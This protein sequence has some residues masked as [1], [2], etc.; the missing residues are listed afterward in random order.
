MKF[1]FV[2]LSRNNPEQLQRLTKTLERVYDNPA[3]ACHHAFRSLILETSM[4]ANTR[5]VLPA[6]KTGWAKW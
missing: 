2:I 1:G 6:L 3:I 5:F 4:F